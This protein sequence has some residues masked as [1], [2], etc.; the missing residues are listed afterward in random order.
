MYAYIQ[1]Y[2][3]VFVQYNLTTIN[4]ADFSNN[5]CKMCRNN[6]K[7]NSIEQ[8]NNVIFLLRRLISTDRVL[9]DVSC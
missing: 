3:N 5:K 2:R 7:Y 4:W 1:I 6:T 9:L 8:V